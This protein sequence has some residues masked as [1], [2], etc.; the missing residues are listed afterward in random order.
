VPQVFEIMAVLS[1]ITN[2]ALIA[3]STTAFQ[4]PQHR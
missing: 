1:V 3:F 2:S 4:V